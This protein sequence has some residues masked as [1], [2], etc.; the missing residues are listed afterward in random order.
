MCPEQEDTE[1]EGDIFS[2]RENRSRLMFLISSYKCVSFI[3]V[4]LIKMLHKIVKNNNY[5][6]Y[7]VSFDCINVYIFMSL[8]NVIFQPGIL[9]LA[10]R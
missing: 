7:T 9:D 2:R 5:T 6:A 10:D 8:L 3:M 4:K 1:E